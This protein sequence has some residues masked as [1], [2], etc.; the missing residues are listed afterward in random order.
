MSTHGQ[1]HARFADRL[2]RQGAFS[3]SRIEA[4]FRAVPRHPFLRSVTAK[5]AYRDR[6]IVTKTE[7]GVAVSASTQPSFMAVMLQQLGLKPGHRV[8]EIGTGTG[9]NAALMAEI[10][11]KHGKVVSVDI[12]AEIVAAARACLDGT[13][14]RDVTV[15]CGDG[16]FGHVAA[17]PYD[18]I[19][20]TVGAGDIPAALREQLAVGGRLVVPLSIRGPQRSIAFERVADVLVGVSMAA[21]DLS[22]SGRGKFAERATRLAVGSDRRLW[23]WCDGSRSIDPVIIERLVSGPFRDVRTGHAATIAET[24]GGLY[25][26]LAL[27]HPLFVQLGSAAGTGFPWVL[28]LPGKLRLT[29]GLLDATSLCVLTTGRARP[30]TTL[31]DDRQ[32]QLSIRE[33]GNGTSTSTLIDLISA[34]DAA[35][36]PGA[37]GLRVVAYPM[38]AG[39]DLSSE[40]FVIDRRWTRLG[41]SW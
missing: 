31:D 1:L 14:Y 41:L 4:A 37:A 40:Q 12:D 13:G 22:T 5:E 28:G 38:D 29:A 2:A 17:A 3:G 23:L 18:R 6:V 33:F 34:W 36:R 39:Y 19:I 11:G 8:L 35:G 10:I 27:H 7:N 9:Y 20:V 25:L 32:L 24:F 26:W 30:A 21:C 15:V 16:T